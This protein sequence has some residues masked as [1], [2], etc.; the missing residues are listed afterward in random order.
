MLASW[1]VPH[2]SWWC[3][4]TVVH[5]RPLWCC[6]E[7]VLSFKELIKEPTAVRKTSV[8]SC[9]ENTWSCTSLFSYAQ[10]FLTFTPKAHYISYKKDGVN[11]KEVISKL[12]KQRRAGLGES[13]KLQLIFGDQRSTLWKS[14]ISVEITTLWAHVCSNRRKRTK[15]SYM[16]GIPYQVYKPGSDYRPHRWVS[17]SL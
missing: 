6:K 12:K 17:S 9:R 2:T 4:P 10:T 1:S 8:P 5:L 11:L 16:P 15:K 14:P 3:V 7:T 13:G